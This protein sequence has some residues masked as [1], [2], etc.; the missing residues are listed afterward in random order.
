MAPKAAPKT[1]YAQLQ[2]DEIEALKAI[3][4]EDFDEIKVKGPWNGTSEKAFRLHLK[5]LQ[6]PDIGLLISVKFPATYPKTQPVISIE[7]VH[8]VR[9]KS[10][11]SIKHIFEDKP[12]TLLGS[13]M[14]FEI[15]SEAIDILVDEA[16]FQL[17]GA[18]L[19][20]LEEERAGYEAQAAKLVKDRERQDVR[21]KDRLKADADKA[22]QQKIDDEISRGREGRRKS[23]DPTPLS[24]GTYSILSFC[25]VRYQ[26]SVYCCFFYEGHCLYQGCG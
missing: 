11:K 21:L 10:L 4:A 16:E 9:E 15:T 20:T 17:K 22:M 26:I 24:Q 1:D 5:P 12:K 25:L 7:N 2:N 13:V 14:I 6:N 3:Y 23:A 8:N 18:D 19:P